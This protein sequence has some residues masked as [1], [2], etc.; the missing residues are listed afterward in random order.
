MV[1]VRPWW[2]CLLFAG[3]ASAAAEPSSACAPD[4]RYDAPGPATG[5]FFR[6]RLRGKTARAVREQL[7]APSCQSATLWRYWI[8]SDCSYEKTVVSV[9]FRGGRVRRVG[10][11]DIITGQECL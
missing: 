7:G 10:A 6:S 1:R 8:P 4:E 5:R 2:I 3:C 11:V 9:W